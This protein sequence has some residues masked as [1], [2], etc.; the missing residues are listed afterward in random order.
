[1]RRLVVVQLVLFA[2]VSVIVIPFGINYVIGPQAFG[3]PIRVYSVMTDA[4]GLT[5]G[6]AVTYRGVS[7]GSVASVISSPICTGC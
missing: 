7:V 4:R 1:M 2:L 6:T 3:T 5:A